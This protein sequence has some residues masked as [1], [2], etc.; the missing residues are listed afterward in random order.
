MVC[1]E[2]MAIKK[3]STI[4]T[5]LHHFLTR[6]HICQTKFKVKNLNPQLYDDRS[7]KPRIVA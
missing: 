2:H 1:P 5:T 6:E 3:G 4:N 7:L